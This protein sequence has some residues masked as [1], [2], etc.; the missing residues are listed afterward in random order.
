MGESFSLADCA[1][2]PSLFYVNKVAPFGS[3]HPGVL[4]YLE[5]VMLRPS[6]ARVLGEA[7]PYFKFFPA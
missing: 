3:T 1:A 6:I 5:R 7:E 2:A 4:R